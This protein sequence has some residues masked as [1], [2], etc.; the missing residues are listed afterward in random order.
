MVQAVMIPMDRLKCTFRRVR[1]PITDG[2]SSFQTED[3]LYFHRWGPPGA[4][5]AFFGGFIGD[6][7]GRA[8]C[9]GLPGGAGPGVPDAL[10]SCQHIDLS[11][12]K[13]DQ[14]GCTWAAGKE[15]LSFDPPAILAEGA[16]LRDGGFLETLSWAE[17]E[18]DGLG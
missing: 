5:P 16:M 7:A 17:T 1:H 10:G 12:G 15:P 4:G 13:L 3:E 11:S 8:P 14:R 2:L 18:S 9:L 6:G